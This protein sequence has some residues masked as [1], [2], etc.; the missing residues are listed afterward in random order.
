MTFHMAKNQIKL[1]S[2]LNLTERGE[3]E[4]RIRRGRARRRLWK[5]QKFS[6]LY[7]ILLF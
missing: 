5:R 6:R 3:K 2:D 4:V 7:S 1:V